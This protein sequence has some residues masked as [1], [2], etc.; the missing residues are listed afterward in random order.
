[1]LETESRWCLAVSRS[2]TVSYSGFVF[3]VSQTS[4]ETTFATE[5]AAEN[6]SSFLTITLEP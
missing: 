3:C 1:M 5:N 2:E 4:N 6:L